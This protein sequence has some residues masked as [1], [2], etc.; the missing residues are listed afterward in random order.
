MNAFWETST[1]FGI[2]ITLFFYGA[3]TV[4]KQKIKHPLM[5]ANNRYRISNVDSPYFN[6]IPPL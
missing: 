3:G 2:F 1:F 4:L 5:I 6:F